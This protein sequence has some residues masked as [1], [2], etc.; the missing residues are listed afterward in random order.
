LPRS[1][2][3]ALSALIFPFSDAASLISSLESRL[4]NSMSADTVEL[5][6]QEHAE[7]LQGLRAQ[8]ARAQE[9]E[10]ELT[11]TQEAESMLWLEFDC[12]LAKERKILSAKYDNEVDELRASLE[13]KV[14]SCDAKSSEL[15]T[16]RALDSKQHDDDLSAW[17]TWDRKLH[18]GLLGLED[19]LRGMLLSSLPSPC[20][21]KPCP[22]FLAALV[23]AFLDSDGAA[24]AALEK[25]RAKQKI[26]S[27]SDPEAK[28]TSEELMALVKGQLHPVA[29]LGGEL[30]QAIASVFKDFW[31][32]RAVPGDIQMLLKWIP[33]VSNR[34]DVWKESSA[35]AGAA[36]ALESV[37]SWYLG[38]I[39]DQ[40]EHLREGGLAALDEAKL[41]QRTRAIA[42]CANT[43]MLF[44]AGESDESL[45]DADFEEPSSAEAS[46]K[47]PEDL[48]DSSIPLSPSGNDFV[49]VARTGDAAPLEPAGSPSAP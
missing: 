17:R 16:L 25:Y 35:R 20:S 44:D 42:E 14:E 32:R 24:K 38:V 46:Q 12:Q 39:L 41:H 9:L 37:L 8:A 29:K 28:F 33:L 15:E 10:M 43:S 45:D 6:K 7:E 5:L 3:V 13:S 47:A 30:C 34:V 21:F 19:A 22:H 1:A 4:A 2:I 18:S 36:Q 11:K 27:C 31:P 26:V 49:L 40:L 23:G 48:A